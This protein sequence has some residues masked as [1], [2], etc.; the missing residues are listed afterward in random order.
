MS[1]T[2]VTRGA[3]TLSMTYM[4]R[5][6]SMTK[7]MTHVTRGAFKSR[8]T[9]F[10]AALLTSGATLLQYPLNLMELPAC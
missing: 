8:I 5:C 1:M 9:C 3:F 2:R 10:R 4:T 6:M 7:S